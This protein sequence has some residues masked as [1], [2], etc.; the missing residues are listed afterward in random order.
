MISALSPLHTNDETI[1]YR[2][3]GNC[4]VNLTSRCTLRCAFC[5]KFNDEWEVQGYD[6]RLHDEPTPDEVLD[7]VGDPTQY[8]EVVFC[9]LGEP[10]LKLDTLLL[11]AR[12]LKK[13]GARVRVN[14]D[15]LA[16]LVHGR[17]VT[18]E[19]VDAVDAISVSMNAQ[20]EETY[21]RHCRPKCSGAYPA[22]LEFVRLARD[23]VREVSV[24]A[25]DGLEGVDIE[26]CARVADELG[27][28]F[29][30]RVLDQVG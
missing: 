19:L 10:L 22:M 26:A 7:A 2:L 17:D 27:V 11:V 3:H 23:H 5:P 29:R 12:V 8:R 9:G 30:R 25:I 21:N 13:E 6:L 16:N 24:S 14:T 15:G 20:D 28:A 18:P 4:Y 1:A